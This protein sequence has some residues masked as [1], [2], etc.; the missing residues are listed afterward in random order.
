MP[1]MKLNPMCKSCVKDCKQPS[2]VTMIS[3]PAFE[4]ADKTIELFDAGGQIVKGVVPRRKPS[5]KKPLKGG[6]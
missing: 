5:K 2:A 6:D 3:C 4:K 1:A